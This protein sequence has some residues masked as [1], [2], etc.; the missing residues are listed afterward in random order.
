MKM[1]IIISGLCLIVAHGASGNLLT[2]GDFE[3]GNTGFTTDYNYL[4][5]HRELP[6]G[7]YGI[8]SY[9]K[10]LHW[11]SLATH[12]DHTSGSGLMMM[13]NGARTP[14]SLVWA[15]TV[16][17]TQNEV[18][19]FSMWASRWA[20]DQFAPATLAVYIN[21]SQ[22]GS[23]YTTLTTRGVWDLFSSNWSS[24]SATEANVEIRL[25][26]SHSLGN[27]LVLDDLSL[28]VIPEPAGAAFV[29]MSLLGGLWIRRF[30]H[31]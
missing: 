3:A 13:V 21:G 26:T 28:E 22:I 8:T 19:D 25:R 9:P 6:E 7:S 20:Q 1:S 5:S 4:T 14:N 29:A 31:I 23:D 2:N 27:D 10:D 15:E 12:V 18:Y 24:E 16:S 17:V 11:D 30:F